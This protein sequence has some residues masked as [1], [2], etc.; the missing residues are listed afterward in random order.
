[1]RVFISHYLRYDIL[2]PTQEFS[3]A[4]TFE[5]KTLRVRLLWFGDITLIRLG[6][7]RLWCVSL[8]PPLLVSGGRLSV[9]VGDLGSLRSNRRLDSRLC[10]T[11]TTRDRF[12]DGV[13]Y[14]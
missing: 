4:I 11:G 7:V 2:T 8:G 14:C 9:V 5:S 3:Y 13:L 1:M 12:K 10:S 6:W